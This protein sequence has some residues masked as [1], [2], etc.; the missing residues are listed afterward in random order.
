MLLRLSFKKL[1]IKAHRP[2]KKAK[3]PKHLKEIKDLIAE[4]RNLKIK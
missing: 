2:S 3:M 4:K 1:H